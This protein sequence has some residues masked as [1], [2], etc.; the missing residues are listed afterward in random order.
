MNEAL[1]LLRT[2]ADNVQIFATIAKRNQE[3]KLTEF[4]N[5]LA[6]V[7]TLKATMKERATADELVNI[8]VRCSSSRATAF[9]QLLTTQVSGGDPSKSSNKR[10]RKN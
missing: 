5:Q 7:N 6:A 8:D 2:K 1:T 10:H 3:D 9:S 4:K